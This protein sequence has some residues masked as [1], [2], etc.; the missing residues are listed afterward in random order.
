MARSCRQRGP[1]VEAPTSEATMASNEAAGRRP[2]R[3]RFRT[4]MLIGHPVLVHSGCQSDRR[5][6]C[7]NCQKRSCKPPKPGRVCPSPTGSIVDRAPGAEPAV[8]DPTVRPFGLPPCGLGRRRDGGQLGTAFSLGAS[9]KDNRNDDEAKRPPV[10]RGRH[11]HIEGQR[12]RESR[13]RTG[14]ERG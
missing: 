2:A 11:L 4:K 13:S 1:R 3:A 8:P 7:A 10:L 9:E 6:D 14:G 12:D 5:R